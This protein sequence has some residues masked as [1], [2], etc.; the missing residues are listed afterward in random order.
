M[1]SQVQSSGESELRFTLPNGS[2]RRFPTGTTGLDVARNISEGL[3]REALAIELD[4]VARDLHLPLPA[5]GAIRILTFDDKEG[6]EVFRHSSAHLLAQAVVALFPDAKP[7][8]GPVV[9]EGFY[10]DFFHAPFTEDDLGRIEK[11]MGE[12]AAQRHTFKRFDVSSAEAK[13]HFADNKFKVELIEGF[14]EG[15]S[16]YQQGETFIDLCR[17]PHV[18]HT[19]QL[20]AVK[21][22]KLAG[23]YWRGDAAREKLQR[24][25]GVSF[26]SKKQLDEHLAALEEAKKRDHRKIGAEMEL[27]AF[28]DEGPGFPF[29]MPNGMILQNEILGFWRL[30]HER[31]GYQEVKTPIMLNESLWHRSGHY[32]NYK[33][34]MYF[35]SIDESGFAV[36]PMNCPGHVLM[37]NAKRHSY[38]ELPLKISEFGLVH[39]HELSGVLHGLFRVRMFTQ[40]DAHIFC[41]ED[42]I[43][44]MIVEVMSLVRSFYGAFGFEDVHVELSTRPAKH[45]GEVAMWDQ[46]EKALE[47]ALAASNTQYKLN[48]GDGAFYGPKI[49]FH[50]RDC[51]K[52]SWQCGTV[53]LDFNLPRRF[54]A[55]YVG[56]DNLP[57]TP[58]MIHRA[59]M[60][61]IERFIGILT[62]HYAGKFPLWLSPVQAMVIPV[63]DKQA[64]YGAQVVAELRAAGIRARLDDRNE[65]LNKKVRDAQLARINYQLV[66]G[67]REIE[68]HAV[69][70][71]TRANRQLG[72]LSVSAFLARCQEEIANRRLPEGEGA[73]A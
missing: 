55:E 25:Y 34:N 39:R 42:Q 28:H 4:G 47:E 57:H 20:K 51:M 61:S 66:V 26:P 22:T 48:P 50:I 19:G 62:E 17:G 30:L 29:W 8:I 37:Y 68:T 44:D 49:D 41:A 54:E 46:A 2:E 11:K 1:A 13:Q 5:S 14:E 12:L 38:R 53:Q 65:T 35:T 9:D 58:V 27:F 15:T 43:K 60:G 7:T 32:A 16:Y 70:V 33:E 56:A 52:R 71:R 10:Y 36:K 40:D 3:A 18:Q 63:S 23:S 69:S 67:D 73:S 59:I 21:L 6:L 72:A 24:I 45:I 64:P 31:L